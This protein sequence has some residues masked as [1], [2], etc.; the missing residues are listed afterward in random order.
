MSEALRLVSRAADLA[1]RRHAGQ[2]WKD[3]RT[4]YVNHLAEVAA[5][6]AGAEAGADAEVIAAAW[7]H[8]CVEDGHAEEAEIEAQFGPRVRQI[9]AELTDDMSL[10]DDVRKQRQVDDI[11]GKSAEARLIKLADELSNVREV[12]EHPPDGWWPERRR[13]YV[14]WGEAVVDAGCRGLDPGLE[15]EFDR[16]RRGAT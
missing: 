2:T 16:V 1:A 5:L 11:A 7:L 6:V 10:P 3:G 15:A 14:E 4:P 13:D 8:D 12:V 9:V